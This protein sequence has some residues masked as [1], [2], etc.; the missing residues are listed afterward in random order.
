MKNTLFKTVVC[1]LTVFA[2][3]MP[4]F[5]SAGIIPLA[6]PI[7]VH[8]DAT[9]EPVKVP[10][11]ET[12]D[13]RIL[14]FQ[15]FEDGRTANWDVSSGSP[16]LVK[17]NN[18]TVYPIQLYDYVNFKN[19]RKLVNFRMEF[20]MKFSIPEEKRGKSWPAL[21]I[22]SLRPEA[23]YEIFFESGE[24]IEGATLR[25]NG[26]E[27]L[28][29]NFPFYDYNEQWIYMRFDINNGAIELYINDETKPILSYNDQNPI[30]PGPLGFARGRTDYFY[31]D[32][33]LVTA[34]KL[35]DGE[36]D[37]AF[38]G[39]EVIPDKT[40]SEYGVTY[41]DTDFSEGLDSSFT[42]VHQNTDIIEKDNEKVARIIG[43]LHI[44]NSSWKDYCVDMDIAL[45]RTEPLS[46]T[47]PFFKFRYTD[48]NNYYMFRTNEIGSVIQIYKVVNGASEWV[49]QKIYYIGDGRKLQLRLEVSGTTM[50]LYSRSKSYPNFEYPILVLNDE[51]LSNGG[52]A[53]SNAQYLTSIDV[54]KL[55]VR[56]ITKLGNIGPRPDPEPLIT[57]AQNPYELWTD[58]DGHWANQSLKLLANT[59]VLTGYPDNTFR[60]DEYLSVKEA[61]KLLCS[62]V[63]ITVERD[64]TD[65]A[66]PYIAVALEKG[67][68]TEGEFNS[69][70]KNITRGELEKIVKAAMNDQTI[71]VLQGDNSGNINADA[72]CTRAEAAE[73]L[74]R[75]YSI[76]FV[77]ADNTEFVTFEEYPLAFANPYKG[78]K[79]E[80][81]EPYVTLKSH[82]I[83]WN[84]IENSAEDGIEKIK[85]YAKTAFEGYAEN[86]AKANIFIVLHFPPTYYWPAD[87]TA[88][89]YTSDQF[90]AR[91][92]N[93]IKK[94]AEV[95]DNDPR[96]GFIQMGFI[97]QWGEMQSPPPTNDV[98]ALMS[99]CFNKYFKNKIVIT[100]IVPHMT[101]FREYDFGTHWDSFGH[102]DNLTLL[103]IFEEDEY[104]ETLWQ[105]VPIYGEVAFDWGEQLGETPNDAVINH[106]DRFI[107]LIRYTHC[108]NL[109]WIAKYDKNDPETTKNAV[110][111][112][113][114][115]GY[116][117]VLQNARYT[118]HVNAGGKLDVSFTV[119]NTGSAPIYYNE[120][121]ELSLLDPETKEVVWKT[122]FNSTDIRT[123]QPDGNYSCTPVYT[124][125]ESF[126]LPEN[127]ADGQYTVALSILDSLGGNVPAI[128]FANTNY[129]EGGRHPIGNI[130][131]GTTT[132]ADMLDS[133][134][135]ADLFT[136][137]LH[138]IYEE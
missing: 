137:R 19:V 17:I 132:K 4:N 43:D 69:Y 1:I 113:K 111:I 49:G 39:I 55:T 117:F 105:R 114:A 84:E 60:P 127:L 116:R 108:S 8:A 41:I 28:T 2:M 77:P 128:R 5:V 15:D 72:S 38:T 122:T 33:L 135:F 118:S 95:F 104:Y 91:L 14:W 109:S 26:V 11:P 63:N 134:Q 99:E 71:I 103:D 3:I 65:W 37:D 53:F 25:R 48:E 23:R 98:A 45:N 101:F 34:R 46:S 21:Y 94:L 85:E 62:T 124:V 44:G 35:A 73:M 47:E 87:M 12:T 131:V 123:W 75:L 81:G 102:W 93:M 78:F 20:N 52:I 70:D 16:E 125:S 88:G 110:D 67:W 68:I 56:E 80:P 24:G 86:N 29:V 18:T 121:V 30:L 97:G 9:A 106:K 51:S 22:K 42:D 138:Y 136:D 107:E 57:P 32:N 126:V 61:L 6:L 50:R 7:N 59:G 89:D 100:N 120:P 54:S 133:T 96:I 112:Q 27:V 58:I 66:S 76:V 10:S 31:I 129:Y 82:K 119:A 36:E 92:E 115:M 64:E 40:A 74:A 13:R 90:K 83:L 79:N 130:S